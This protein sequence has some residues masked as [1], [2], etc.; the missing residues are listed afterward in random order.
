MQ[1]DCSCDAAQVALWGSWQ[2]GKGLWAQRRFS[3]GANVTPFP[4]FLFSFGPKDLRSSDAVVTQ[5]Q[6]PQP[7][8]PCDGGGDGPGQLIALR[9]T[10]ERRTQLAK[11]QS[12]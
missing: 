3:K 2:G 8:H 5:A 4:L 6:L 9:T 12:S 10:G 1:V 11:K 7:R